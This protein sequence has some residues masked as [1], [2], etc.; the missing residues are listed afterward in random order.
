M[1][2]HV[3]KG[4][5]MHLPRN[6]AHIISHVCHSLTAPCK[7]TGPYFLCWCAQEDLVLENARAEWV[8]GQNDRAKGMWRFLQVWEGG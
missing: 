5:Y 8:P 2:I 3:P 7:R 6:S 4:V 1:S